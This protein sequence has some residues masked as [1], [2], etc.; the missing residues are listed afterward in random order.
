MKAIF[1]AVLEEMFSVDEN[2]VYTDELV[3]PGDIELRR[4]EV[5]LIL[6]T[7]VQIRLISWS[8]DVLKSWNDG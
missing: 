2:A 4:T 1:F 6:N 8:T 7:Q 5:P 3:I